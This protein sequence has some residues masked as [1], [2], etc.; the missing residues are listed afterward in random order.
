[1]EVG[2]CWYWSAAC[3]NQGQDLRDSLG[4]AC[5]MAPR[6]QLQFQGSPTFKMATEEEAEV[7][8]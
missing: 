8:R 3:Y 4:F 2:Y 6:W 1:M 5:L 7:H